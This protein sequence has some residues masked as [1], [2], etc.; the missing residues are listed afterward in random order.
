MPSILVQ[1]F[2]YYRDYYHF[3]HYYKHH[4]YN[5]ISG[6]KIELKSR[7][8]FSIDMN[9]FKLLITVIAIT[10]T[11]IFLLLLIPLIL[12]QILLYYRDYYHFYHYYKHHQYNELSC[13][14]DLIKV[15]CGFQ[16]FHSLY[17]YIYI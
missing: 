5:E 11:V 7:A 6:H 12:L 3:Y 15:T 4:Q 2:L 1:I 16:H 9:F 8:V 17:I 10:K 13:H 14:N